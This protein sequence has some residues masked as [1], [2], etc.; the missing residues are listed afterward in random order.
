MRRPPPPLQR[1]VIQLPRVAGRVPGVLGLAA[2]VKSQATRAQAF[3]DVPQLPGVLR[4][5]QLSVLMVSR[6]QF[7][8]SCLE[9]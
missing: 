5:L 2:T 1:T 6:C 4:M 3:E 9:S 8:V 7:F